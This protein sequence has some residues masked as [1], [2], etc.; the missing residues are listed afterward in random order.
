M[1]HLLFNGVEEK[2]VCLGSERTQE[3]EDG[4]R[5]YGV[6]EGCCWERTR[7]TSLVGFGQGEHGATTR[8]RRK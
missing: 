2:A 5:R 4:E 6:Q 7:G 1:N 3:G 8:D